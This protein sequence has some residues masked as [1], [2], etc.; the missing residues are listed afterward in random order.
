MTETSRWQR[1]LVIC[2]CLAVATAAVYWPVLHFGF[3]NVDDRTY[4]TENPFRA[5]AEST[6]IK[7]SRLVNNNRAFMSL[8]FWNLKIFELPSLL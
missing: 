8:L 7:D 1:S 4:V 6:M 2:S 3:V 5:K